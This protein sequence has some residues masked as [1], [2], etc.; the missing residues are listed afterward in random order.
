M[1]FLEKDLEEIIFNAKNSD[2]YERGLYMPLKKKR[3]FKIGNYGIADIITFERPYFHSE[4]KCKMKGT[5]TIFEFKKDVINISAFL[6]AIRYLRG[7]KSYLE[8]RGLEE[9]YN[10]KIVLIGRNLD[11][12]SSFSYLPDLISNDI[13]ETDLSSVSKFNLE[14]FTYS[15]DL[16]GLKFR[17]EFNYKLTKEG[18]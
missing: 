5:I 1:E 18:F 9:N 15:Y 16:D 12:N 7:I 6:Q 13:E 14:L 2:L 17:Q 4:Y 11:L 10:Y 8:K 3:Q